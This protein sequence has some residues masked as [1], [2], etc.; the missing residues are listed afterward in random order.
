MGHQ[1][2]NC[3]QPLKDVFKNRP[4]NQSA[5]KP[6]EPE[7]VYAMSVRDARVT[8]D[9]VVGTILV[10]AHNA[11]ALIDPGATHS[12]ISASF[13]HR[14]KLLPQ[15]LDVD[16]MIDIPIGKSVS[17]YFVFKSYVVQIG[18]RELTADFIPLDIQDF[19]VILGMD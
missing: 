11:Y 7:R 8:N 1:V 13:V 12:V 6:K 10:H 15:S 4:E 17:V 14:L 16:L 3:P 5:Q 2:K 9:V 18:G 19:D